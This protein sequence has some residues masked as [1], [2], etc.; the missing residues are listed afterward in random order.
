MKRILDYWMPDIENHFAKAIKKN[1]K[2]YGVPEY[3]YEIRNEALK[4]VTNFDRCIDVGANLGLWSKPLSDVFSQVIAFEPLDF[5]FECL[6][7]N[8]KGRNVILN[9]FALGDINSKIDMIVTQYN[10]GRSHVNCDTIGQGTIDIKRLDDL[11]LPYFSFMKIDVEGFE[12][13]VLLGG[14]NTIKE[15]KPVLVV[16]EHNEHSESEKILNSFGARK[17]FSSRIDHLYIWN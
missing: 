16:E 10:T 1:L 7:E 6:Q 11:N 9:Q 3:Q 5:A 13:N 8:T 2:R 4:H 12:P 17:I 15:Y 14:A